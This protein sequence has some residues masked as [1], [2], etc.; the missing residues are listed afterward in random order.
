MIIPVQGH[1]TAVTHHAPVMLVTERNMLKI[2][3]S[4]YMVFFGV[5]GQ[6][7]KSASASKFGAPH[8]DWRCG[9]LR[10]K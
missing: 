7:G 2:K 8:D 3:W 4:T 10:Y 1:R 9:R 6:S 5:V